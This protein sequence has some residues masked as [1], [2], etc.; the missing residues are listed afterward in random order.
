MGSKASGFRVTYSTMGMGADAFHSAFDEG[1]EEAKKHF[2]RSYPNYIGGEPIESAEA[3]ENKSPSD[4]RLVLGYFAKAAR[5]EAADAV[6]AAKRSFKAWRDMGWKNRLPLLRRAA[7][8]ISERK[9]FLAAVMSYEAGKSR[10]E[11]MGDVEESADMIR[12]YC[13]Q[14]EAA[15]GFVKPMGQLS[16]E[17]HVQSVLRPFG[18]WAVISPFN[19]PLALSVGMSAGA[20]IAGNTVVFKPSHDT[21]WSGLLLYEVFRDA[22]LPAGVFNFINGPGSVVGKE[23]T[24]NPVVDGLIFTGS[25]EV[26]MS[27]Y[28]QFSKDFPKPC[29][30]E[31]GGKNPAIIMP[32]A[33]LE[34]AAE[35]VMRSAFGLGGQ[36]CSACSRVYVHKDVEDRFLDLLVQKT[37]AIKIGDPIERDI[38]LGPLI[39]EAAFRNFQDY[40]ETVRK[41]GKILT[42]GGVITEGDFQYGYFVEPTVVTGLPKDHAFFYEELFVPLLV[43]APVDSLDEALELSNRAMY[44]LTAG[45]FSNDKKEVEHF[46][47]NIETGVL[48]ANR[49][50]G[51]TTGAWPGVNPFCGWKGSG[52]SGKGCCGPYYVQQFMREQSRTVMGTIG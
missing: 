48:Y 39:N 52:S 29:I 21:P 34:Q 27:I 11:S 41:D 47:D 36:K 31:M 25:K 50:S 42:G 28:Q 19:F 37:E 17:E 4:T 46:F 16:S 5:Q 13:Q 20:L 6:A 10:L 24:N 23:F 2:G 3:T 1:V 45:I 38:F 26:G 32:S 33:D 40:A 30:T 8:L 12:Y 9:Y 15:D 18:V 14:M 43:A 35:G 51:A 49:R 44:G 7:D 22:G